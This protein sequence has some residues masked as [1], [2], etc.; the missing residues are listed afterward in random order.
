MI[1]H[2]RIPKVG[3]QKVLVLLSKGDIQMA[4]SFLLSVAT[5]KM[6]TRTSVRHFLLSNC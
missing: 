2:V 6:T 1:C 5:S 3:K 4:I